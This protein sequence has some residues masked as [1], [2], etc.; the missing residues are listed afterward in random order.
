LGTAAIIPM[1]LMFVDFVVARWQQHPD[2]HIYHYAPYEPAALKRLMGRYATR[3]EEIDEMLRARLL[4]DLFSVIRHSI[5]ASVVI[6]SI[7]RLEPLYGFSRKTPRLHHVGHPLAEPVSDILQPR[8]AA[9]LRLG[10]WT[11]DPSMALCLAD[12]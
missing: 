7:K 4:V 6:Y 3:E 12:A 2:L 9:S 11:D 8:L 10:E 1:G 5:R